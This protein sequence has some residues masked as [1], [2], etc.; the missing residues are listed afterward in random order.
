MDEQEWLDRIK[1]LSSAWRDR[2]DLITPYLGRYQL[3]RLF[4]DQVWFLVEWDLGTLQICLEDAR[5]WGVFEMHRR[6]KIEGILRGFWLEECASDQAIENLITIHS[7]DPQYLKIN[8]SSSFPKPSRMIA[9]LKRK[10]VPY[11]NK[12]ANE[13][14]KLYQSANDF[15]HMSVVSILGS[16]AVDRKG[17]HTEIKGSLFEIG[18]CALR[19]SRVFEDKSHSRQIK[20]ELEEELIEL[21]SQIQKLSHLTA[22][23]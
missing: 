15:A 1:N 6:S 21:E 22:K 20:T 14:L 16:R 18:V 23:T 5:A 19:I 3:S 7:F 13:F 11:I 10:D 17:I 12:R 8:F 9:N 2:C 4:F